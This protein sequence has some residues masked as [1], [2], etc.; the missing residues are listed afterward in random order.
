MSNRQTGR[1]T[2]TAPRAPRAP[3]RSKP[4]A[5]PP[6][7][8]LVDDLIQRLIAEIVDRRLLP[9]VRL[10]EV[11]LAERFGVSRTPIRETLRQLETIG[12][13]QRRPNRGVVVT[14]MPG[15]RLAAL[16]ETLVE[17]EASCAR[18]AAARMPIKDKKRLREAHLRVLEVVPVDDR[19]GFE[20]VNGDLHQLIWAGALND[21]L[22]ALVKTLRQR[23]APYR[24]S[25]LAAD[26]RLSASFEEHE[27]VVEAIIS[28]DGD[29]AA[30]AMRVHLRSAGETS[31]RF[32]Y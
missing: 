14:A 29:A 21:E 13:V 25:R 17:L 6:R 16:F 32:R 31:W 28:G 27:A 15:E 8:S 4:A 2:G 18:F 7:G 19:S 23:L 30:E 1:V 24:Q 22:V 11:T 12:L 5:P 26:G 9:G 3:R 20:A 10:E